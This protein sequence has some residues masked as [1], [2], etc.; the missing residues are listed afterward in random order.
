[1]TNPVTPAVPAEITPDGSAAPAAPTT[2]VTPADLAA[3]VN[4]GG[5]QTVE[6]P[7]VPEFKAITSQEE[8]DRRIG[9]RI[10][11]IEAKYPNYDD[12]KAKAE[13]YDQ[14]ERAKL[15]EV[16]QK[17]L[18]I[19]EL[20]QR[21]ADF[22]AREQERQFNDLRTGIARAKGLPDAL[23]SRLTGTT[24]EELE[25]DAESLLSLVPQAPVAV[26]TQTPEPVGGGAP[27]VPGTNEAKNE[28]LIDDLMRNGF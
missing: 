17:D 21:I 1:M 18:T 27:P 28:S 8:F 16:Q 23:A 19:E 13:K 7:A 24:K 4:A 22:E 26:A 9:Q 5:A 2:T 10:G 3:Q 14:S 12:L 25:A 6:T 15:D 20:N 11:Q